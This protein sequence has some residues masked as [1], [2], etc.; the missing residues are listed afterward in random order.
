MGW[1]QEPDL[2]QPD[3]AW[4][5]RSFLSSVR[6]HACSWA[7]WGHLGV[8]AGGLCSGSHPRYVVPLSEWLSAL[9]SS[10]TRRVRWQSPMSSAGQ[11]AGF[12]ECPGLRPDLNRLGL[13]P[14][15]H[16]P[17]GRGVP[18]SPGQAPQPPIWP[19]KYLTYSG[20]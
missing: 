18:P 7:V 12:Q 11:Q 17:P 16:L 5:G 9:I 2:G 10:H 20:K 6:G 8:G 14:P 15:G 4:V 19:S 13:L 3:L 1:G